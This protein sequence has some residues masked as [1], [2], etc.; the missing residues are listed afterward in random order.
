MSKVAQIPPESA[1]A[2]VPVVERMM[3]GRVWTS[4]LL[5][6]A[7]DII[8]ATMERRMALFIFYDSDWTEPFLFSAVRIDTYPQG[9]VACIVALAGERIRAAIEWREKFEL[10]CKMQNCDHIYFETHSKL[11]K[12]MQRYGY[13]SPS[14]AVYKPLVTVQ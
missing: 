8:F 9:R 10:W 12:I 5:Y 4:P 13:T 7:K 3:N 2:F 14:V 11:A 6:S 1:L